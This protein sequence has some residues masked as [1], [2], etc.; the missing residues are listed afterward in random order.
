MNRQSRH[1]RIKDEWCLS[2]IRLCGPDALLKRHEAAAGR[3]EVQQFADAAA[4][5]MAGYDNDFGR[6]TESYQPCMLA[7]GIVF[8]GVACNDSMYTGRGTEYVVAFD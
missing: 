3:I 2:L 7:I 4:L 5:C 8:N 1:G 6:M